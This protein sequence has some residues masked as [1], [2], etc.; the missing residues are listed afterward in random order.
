MTKN[1]EAPDEQNHQGLIFCKSFLERILLSQSY[2]IKFI[3]AF[4]LAVIFLCV[5]SYAEPQDTSGTR[6]RGKFLYFPFFIR[7]PETSVGFGAANVLFFKTRQ[8]DSLI[9]TSDL[10]L[11]ALYT[12]RKQMVFVLG[13]SVYFPEENVILRLQTSY[14]HYPDKTWGI[15]N[16]SPGGLKEDYSIHQ[17]Y[18]NPQLLKRLVAKWYAGISYEFQHIGDFVYETNGVFDQQDIAGRYGGNM[19]G[20]G[21]S[22]S[23]DSRNNA[24]SPSKGISGE[25]SLVSHSKVFGSDFNFTT[26]SLDARKYFSLSPK[27]VLA[28]QFILKD[29]KG[30]VPIRSLAMLGG[31]EMMRG[32]YYGRFT[33]KDL[34]A[35]QLELRQF[36]FWR[37]GI[38]AFGGLGQVAERISDF[39]PGDLHYA[40][41]GGL[42]LMVSKSEKLNL[43]IDYGFG[44]QSGG[45]YV[46]LKEA[47]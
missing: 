32:Y 4:L 2:M 44:R 25:L 29:N 15:G 8:H 28:M 1:D 47:F 10:N 33:D 35:Y 9:R 19:A 5:K 31:S 34:I 17:F 16:D 40:G 12:L 27:R 45:L 23:Y 20:G 26:I 24:Y 36:L 46:I 6:S 18:I 30:N 14:S 43:R 41:G 42:R 37:I 11:V 13:S 21:L 39:S 38:V 3:Q 7:S 22:F